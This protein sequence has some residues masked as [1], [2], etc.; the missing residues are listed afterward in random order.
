MFQRI[1]IVLLLQ[2]VSL[3]VFAQHKGIELDNKPTDSS[4][5]DFNRRFALV[6]GNAD[7][8]KDVLRNP[9]NDAKRI[10]TLL[11][12]YG[13]KVMLHTNLSRREM[14]NVINEFG[15]SITTQKGVS[16]FYYSGHGIQ[17]QAQNYLLPLKA[18]IEKEPEIEDEAVKLSKLLERMKETSNSL[19]V[20]IL[21]ACRNNPFNDAFPTL[22]KGLTD[23]E[24]LPSNTSILFATTPGNVAF[25]GAGSNSPFTEALAESMTEN[26]EFYQVVRKVVKR[27]KEKTKLAQQPAITGSP[28]DEFYF[29]ARVTKPTLHLLSIGISD[30]QQNMYNLQF[31]RKDA[32]DVSAAFEKQQGYLYERVTS[33]TLADDAASKEKILEAITSIKK[34]VRPGDVIMMYFSGHILS[35]SSAKQVDNGTGGKSIPLIDTNL[36]SYLIPADADFD[37]IAMTGVNIEFIRSLLADMPCKSVLFIDG[38]YNAATAATLSKT[39]N[40]VSVFAA[41]GPANLKFS[42]ES[43]EFKNSIFA[44]ALVKGI[45]G[46]ADLHH[47]GYIDLRSLERYLSEE[48]GKL[49]NN[50]QQPSAYFPAG[51]SNF[52]I[53]KTLELSK[54]ETLINVR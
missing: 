2:V 23:K 3:I 4:T 52:Q 34:Q 43:D 9:V 53:S 20:V 28:E 54:K 7:Y 1:S 6:I 50:M 46:A 24:L 26:I 37:H 41:T 29:T 22:A 39:E 11:E 10:A 27:V 31:A 48:V 51:L 45:N 19:N 49:T 36:E 18:N 16:F 21:D 13:F 30:Y 14:N 33:T 15:D 44:Y 42:F 8:D 12:K 17:Y 5:I 40:G 35:E 32:M 38:S 25:D 47:S